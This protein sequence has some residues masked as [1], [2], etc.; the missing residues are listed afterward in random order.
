MT[1]IRVEGLVKAYGRRQLPVLNEV[2]FEL[3]AGKVLGLLGPNGAGKTTL[4][5]IILGL[6]KPDSGK[7]WLFGKEGIDREAKKRLGFLP[8]ESYL[9]S[10]L[11]IRE[12]LV[13]TSRIY[14]K[15]DREKLDR[16]LGLIGLSG[17]ADRKIGECSKGMKR[18]A[19]LG[20][21]LIHDPELLILDEPTSGYDP[22][23]MREVKD[24]IRKLNSEGKTLLICSHQL[25][26]VQ[27]LCDEIVMLHHG[28]VVAQGPIASLLEE[29][30]QMVIPAQFMSE[31]VLAAL[32]GEGWNPQ[33]TARR[34]LDLETFFVNKVKDWESSP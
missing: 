23:G 33:M 6:V 29:K 17:V 19:A 5:K 27:D 2:G 9:Y 25:S 4:I 7:F 1:P 8:E 11:T 18:R 12:T 14:G 24:L 20:Q 16:M 30:E 13:M 22:I 34:T 31:T 28:Q 15:F 21:A 10:F 32:K 26:E 3:G